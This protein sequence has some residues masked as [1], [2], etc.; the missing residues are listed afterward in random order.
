MSKYELNYLMNRSKQIS[1]YKMRL[2]SRIWIKIIINRKEK[3]RKSFLQS[4]SNAKALE[5]ENQHLHQQIETLV[6]QFTILLS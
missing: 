2:Y 6:I 5:E 1:N 3:E 4:I